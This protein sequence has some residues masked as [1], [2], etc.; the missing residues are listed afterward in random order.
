M[1]DNKKFTSGVE[2]LFEHGG[3]YST[4]KQRREKAKV[5]DF[6]LPKERKYPYKVN[7]KIS[8]KLLRAAITR[9]GQYKETSVQKRAERLYYRHCSKKV[10]RYA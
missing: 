4:P 6:L 10:K 3:K 7:G 8:C 5:S 1:A 9:A 2:K